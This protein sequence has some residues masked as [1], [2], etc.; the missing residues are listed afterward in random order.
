MRFR[1]NDV[2]TLNETEK[3]IVK[4]FLGDG[5]QGE[6]YEKERCCFE[7]K[8]HLYVVGYECD[9]TGRYPDPNNFQSVSSV[10]IALLSDLNI[11]RQIG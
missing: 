7:A 9:D 11:Q 4:D 10:T 6:V 3:I 5:G 8:R 1:K 2:I